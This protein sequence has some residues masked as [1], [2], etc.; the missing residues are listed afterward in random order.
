MKCCMDVD[1]APRSIGLSQE[2][3]SIFGPNLIDEAEATVCRIQENLKVAK[4][5]Q[6]SYANKRCQPIEFEVGDHVYLRVSPMKYVKRFG[7]KG[8]L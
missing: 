3:N 5:R 7:M 1:A 4:S 6:E 8:N 2:R